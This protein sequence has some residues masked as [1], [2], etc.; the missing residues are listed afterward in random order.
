VDYKTAKR[1]NPVS[2]IT[3]ATTGPPQNRDRES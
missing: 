3:T 1:A 2:L